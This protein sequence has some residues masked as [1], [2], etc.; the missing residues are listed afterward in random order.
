MRI[1][2]R[3]FTSINTKSLIFGS[4]ILIACA[5]FIVTGFGSLKFS[6]PDSLD[7]G[8]AATV[9][10][11]QISMRELANYLDQKGLGQ[12]PESTKKILAMQ[13]IK[14]LISQKILS[15]EALNI[16]WEVSDQEIADLIRS[17][18]AFLDPSTHEFSIGRFKEFV[19]NQQTSEV[20]FYKFIRNQMRV[21]K[22]EKFLL[23]PL[24]VSSEIAVQNYITE[25][26]TFQFDYAV[27]EVPENI[28]SNMVQE[29]LKAFLAD[30]SNETSIKNAYNS[31]FGKY[32]QKA[33]TRVSTILISY[34]D[35]Q[36][37][38]GEGLS[39]TKEQAKAMIESLE[40]QI[41][42]NGNSFSSLATKTNDDLN[43]LKAKGDIGF[44][45]ETNL[46]PD[47]LKAISELSSNKTFSGVIDTPFGFRLFKFVEMKPSINK[48]IEDVKEDIAK[49]ILESKTK[50]SA[51]LELRNQISQQLLK[52]N[53]AELNKILTNYQIP[54]QTIE[55]TYSIKDKTVGHLAN[56]T[57]LTENVLYIK[58]PGD[59]IPKIVKVENKYI[60]FRAKN[61]IAPDKPEE[62]KLASLQKQMSDQYTQQFAEKTLTNY[63]KIYEKENKIK[64]NP[65]V[66][67]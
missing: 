55:K 2:S 17:I 46:D 23:M 40:K 41:L 47:S 10:N 7:A 34:K 3:T 51:E 32:H 38:I 15:Q 25:N 45:D 16:G 1:G 60:V 43:A 22:M 56:S 62:E 52:N 29:K 31:N 35:A 26:T 13:A 21:Q 61:V 44:V 64:I 20:D 53:T 4:I 18:P 48:K 36:R 9:D 24:S 14:Q 19:N 49:E 67:K 63:E 65:A 5:A 57:D 58:Q 28:I 66:A 59:F 27:V 11:Q 8:T 30:K 42:K 33:K 12:L 54:W 6:S 37:P 50:I 39:R